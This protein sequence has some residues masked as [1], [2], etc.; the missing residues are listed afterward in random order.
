MEGISNRAS[1]CLSATVG[2]PHVIAHRGSNALYP[3]NTILSFTQAIADDRT[4]TG[5]GLVAT[6]NYYGDLEYLTTKE[7]PNCKIARLQDFLDLLIKPENSKVWAVIDI[8]IDNP[9]SIMLLLSTILK[10]YN[11]DLNYFKKRLLLG[12]WHPKFLTLAKTQL[13]QLP[14]IHI[15]FSLSI[16]K[17]YFSDADGYSLM[18]ASLYDEEAKQ[19]IEYAHKLG[20]PVFAWTINKTKIFKE[21]VELGIDGIMTDESKY[22][23]K[24]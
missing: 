2:R 15:G 10:S 9:P 14:I 23:A 18:F 24:D 8:K 1:F 5:K 6:C 22:F 3:E 11:D 7:P 12:I 21:C 4:T 16:A 13:P 20:K 17:N 19:F